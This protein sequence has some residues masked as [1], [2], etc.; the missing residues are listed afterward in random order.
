MK[1]KANAK[2]QSKNQLIVKRVFMETNREGRVFKDVI[3]D[4]ASVK[5]AYEMGLVASLH[6]MF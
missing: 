3:Y 5:A 2:N 6:H 1:L 4:L